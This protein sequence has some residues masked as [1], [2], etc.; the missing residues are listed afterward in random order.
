MET[1]TEI[2]LKDLDVAMLVQYG[3]EVLDP[4]A[5]DID[6]SKYE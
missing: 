2:K 3:V 4:E 6:L 5:I 1:E